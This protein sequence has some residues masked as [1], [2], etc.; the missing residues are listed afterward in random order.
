MISVFKRAKKTSKGLWAYNMLQ[1][2]RMEKGEGPE[3]RCHQC[4]LIDYA[5]NDHYRR[6]PERTDR[7]A[8]ESGLL[9][10]EYRSKGPISVTESQLC[11]LE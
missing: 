5:T 7:I 4:L 9:H 2:A 3:P 1:E 8:S 6:G 11:I 10:S